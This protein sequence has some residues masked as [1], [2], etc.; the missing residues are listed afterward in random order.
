MCWSP[1]RGPFAFPSRS[2]VAKFVAICALVVFVGYAAYRLAFPTYH[3]RY[4]LTLAVDVD[5][6]EHTGSGV[7]GISYQPLPDW[8]VAGSEGLHFG[9]E[10]HGY[11]VTVDLGDR[12]LLFLIYLPPL[13]KASCS[14][15]WGGNTLSTL[16][17][18]AFG[19]PDG[20]PRSY[21]GHIVRKLQHDGGSADVP[22]AKL[23]M[24]LRFRNIHDRRSNEEVD[25]CDLAATYGPGVRLKRATLEITNDPITPMP[26]TWPKWLVDD[27]DHI[28]S[29]DRSGHIRLPA[30]SFKGG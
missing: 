30:S 2:S 29:R 22:F 10:M 11:A 3:L 21:M 1:D 12:G 15:P 20:G 16:P 6:V 17:L 25:P 26:A 5:G 23:P 8:F 18:S 7:I 13:F 28:F 19:L 9:G 27:K 14:P 24:L 4:R